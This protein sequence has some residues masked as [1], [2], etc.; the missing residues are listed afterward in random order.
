MISHIDGT[1]HAVAEI[2]ALWLEIFLNFLVSLRSASGGAYAQGASSQNTKGIAKADTRPSQGHTRK[3]KREL[4]SV[5]LGQVD[6]L[7][8]AFN[9]DKFE[10]SVRLDGFGIVFVLD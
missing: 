3:E 9:P 10:R 7:P 2:I 1:N 8:A 5:I 6:G 4:P